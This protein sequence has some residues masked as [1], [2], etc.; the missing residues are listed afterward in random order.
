VTNP[1]LEGTVNTDIYYSAGKVGIGTN[2]PSQKLTIAGSG[3]YNQ[4]NAAAIVLDNT[5]AAQK[6]EWHAL[7]DGNMQLADYTGAASRLIIKKGT[8]AGYL[9]LDGTNG[10]IGIGTASPI[11][12]LDVNGTIALGGQQIASYGSGS[13][14][15]GDVVSGDGLTP[16]LRL[17]TNDTERLRIDGNGNVGIG[18]SNPQRKLH[19]NASSGWGELRLEGN[20]ISGS[21]IELYSNGIALADIYSTLSK[22]L[23]FRTNGSAEAMRINSNGSI[24]IA[25]ANPDAAYK[26]NV[27]GKIKAH[28]LYLITTGWSDFV[29]SKDYKLRSLQEVERHIKEKGHLPD[30]PSEKEVVANGVAVV[31]MHAKLLQKIEELTLY[32]IEQDKINEEQRKKIESLERENQEI[33]KKLK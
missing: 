21:T 3:T 15:I 20:A 12:K 32:V 33:K 2:N 25:T 6:W 9:Y 28:E 26:L 14:N 23:I 10:N 1:W 7:D 22:D 27:N 30:I 11:A 17:F 18:T 29:F 5:T 24:G 13:I 19:V 8:V 4:V 16:T 31:D